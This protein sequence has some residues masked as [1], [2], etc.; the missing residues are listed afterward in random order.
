MKGQPQSNLDSVTHLLSSTMQSQPRG[1]KVS[2]PRK[3][4]GGHVREDMDIRTKPD[5]TA[6]CSKWT[7]NLGWNPPFTISC[8]SRLHIEAMKITSTCSEAYL[9]FNDSN[10]CLMPR[11]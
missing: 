8:D 7:A 5:S 2:V 1:S 3:D 11:L 4:Q 10:K 6:W 9:T